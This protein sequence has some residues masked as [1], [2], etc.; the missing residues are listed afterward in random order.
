[1]AEKEGMTYME[2]VQRIDTALV[3][4]IDRVKAAPRGYAGAFDPVKVDEDRLAQIYAFDEALLT[5]QDQ[6]SS[7][8]VALENAIGSEGVEIVLDQLEMLVA[9]LNSVLTRRSEVMLL[10]QN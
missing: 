1:L 6:L 2:Q 5:Y 3:T 8:L 7:G 9:E 4:F 10:L